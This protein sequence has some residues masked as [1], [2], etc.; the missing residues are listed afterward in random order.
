[1]Q[2]DY[3]GYPTPFV[4]QPARLSATQFGFDLLGLGD[5]NYTVQ[6][7]TNFSSTNWFTLLT[8]NLPYDSAFFIQDNQA[9]NHQRF[10]RVKVGP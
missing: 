5:T 1:L 7:S 6:F 4:R 10:Y 8:T 9:T 2:V 3:I